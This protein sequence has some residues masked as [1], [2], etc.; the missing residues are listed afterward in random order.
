MSGKLINEMTAL[1]IQ[2]YLVSGKSSISQFYSQLMELVAEGDKKIHAFV[3]L[4]AKCVQAQ[5][6][7]LADDRD[8]GREPGPLYGVPIGLKDIIDTS[9]F[10]TEYGSV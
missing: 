1:E 2:E 8:L 9:D 3:N 5:T 10:P 7:T 6:Q 4:D